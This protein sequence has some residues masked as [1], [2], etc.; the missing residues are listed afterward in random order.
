MRPLH[1]FARP[2]HP[3][4]PKYSW[5]ALFKHYT[6]PLSSYF[7]YYALARVL[8]VHI[9][10]YYMRGNI[11]SAHLALKFRALASLLS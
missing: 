4:I 7:S 10:L 5:Y 6:V 9:G 3:V 8:V 2:T 11:V 1:G